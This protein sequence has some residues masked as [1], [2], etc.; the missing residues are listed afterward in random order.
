M[1]RDL[2]LDSATDL[3]LDHLKVERNLAR[4][5]LEAYARDLGALRGVLA[6]RGV[7]DAGRVTPLDLTDHLLA[8]AEAG[9]AARSRARALVAIRGLFRFLLAE[10]RIDHDPSE[11]L[12]APRAGRR[13]PEVLGTEEVD[14]L[15]PGRH[16]PR[17]PRRRHARHA[18]RHWPA[19]LRAV[20]PARRR[21]QPRRRLPAGDRQGLE[22]PPR[23][24]RRDRPAAHPRLPRRRATGARPQPRRA[25]ALPH[26]ARPSGSSSAATPAP[27][28]SA[29]RSRLTSCATPSPPTSSSG[30]PTCAPCRPCWATPT[31]PRRRS[32]LT[33][34]APV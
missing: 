9:L 11:T 23:P 31:S 2:D 8:L 34:R 26:R 20:R 10:R 15:P 28:G 29:A 30:A 5:S 19:G 24:P 3:Y 12:D 33:S 22:D 4:N 16:P 1:A 14:R 21:R 13:L 17:R 27:P 18:L 6:S 32:T 7:T 25:R